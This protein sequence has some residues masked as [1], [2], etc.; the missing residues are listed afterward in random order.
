M[1]TRHNERKGGKGVHG[2]GPSQLGDP[3]KI[4]GEYKFVLIL[5]ALYNCLG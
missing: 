5:L 4:S 3:E 1:A 2:P